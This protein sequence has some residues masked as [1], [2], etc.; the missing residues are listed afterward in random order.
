MV[1]GERPEFPRVGDG[2]L[3]DFSAF[4]ISDFGGQICA[5]CT[6]VHAL[7]CTY[8]HTYM[9]KHTYIHTYM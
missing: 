1:S 6:S 7:M 2:N 3:S 5:A 8:T 4:M 9:H